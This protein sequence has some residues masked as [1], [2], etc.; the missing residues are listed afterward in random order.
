VPLLLLYSVP[1][2]GEVGRREVEAEGGG[3]K[4]KEGGEKK[5]MEKG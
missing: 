4:G 2:R 3:G 5:E 1:A